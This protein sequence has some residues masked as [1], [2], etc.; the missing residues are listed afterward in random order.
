[1]QSYWEATR[2]A[3]VV[4]EPLAQS[5]SAD[6]AVV[7][8][9]FTGLATAYFLA[10][11]GVS[12]VVVEAERLGYGASGRNGGQVLSGWPVEIV[13]VAERHGK[14]AAEALWS[15]SEEALARVQALAGEERIDCGLE[16]I[17]HLEAADSRSQVATLERELAQISQ[18]VKRPVAWWDGAMIESRIGTRAYRGGLF[19]PGS[20]AFHP[21]NYVL[22]LAAAVG[23]LGGQ[24]YQETTIESIDAV[25]ERSF[26]L[27]TSAGPTITASAVVLATNAYI[28]AFAHW[29]RSRILPVHSAQIAVSLANPNALPERMPTV[30]DTKAELN[31][32]RRI[33]ERTFLF[34]GRALT[35]ELR[36]ERFDSL[37]QQLVRLFP[38]LQGTR[39]T[40]Q[41]A[42]RIALSYDFLPH[43]TQ[44]PDGIW[45]VGGYTGHGAALSTEMGYLLSEVVTGGK[46][47][48][49]LEA[50]LAL[51]WRRF[52]LGRI[53]RALFPLVLHVMDMR[54]RR[55]LARR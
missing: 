47:D 49:R 20:L 53:S 14:S 28:P 15:L 1:M 45:A 33:G 22:G 19:D 4:S 7:G 48:E 11:R 26:R 5:M 3:D 10:R 24:I 38:Q 9:G 17:G 30:S 12:V 54:Q 18:W 35:S 46:P 8:A 52:P 16:A 55:A 6:V 42:G 37:A 23:R 29:L 43:M 36:A 25:G 40:H 39:V 13:T 2:N 44:M 34:G 31:Y 41:W 21:L 51:P 32:Y 27:S 50:L